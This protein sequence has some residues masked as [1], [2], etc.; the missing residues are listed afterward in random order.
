MPSLKIR[1][2]ENKIL[3]ELTDPDSYELIELDAHWVAVHQHRRTKRGRPSVSEAKTIW[4]VTEIQTGSFIA[5]G[6]TRDEV[7]KLAKARVDKLK[8][9]Q[10]LS[11]PIANAIKM[12]RKLT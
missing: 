9:E 8:Q 11:D 12:L 6:P 5:K 10:K 1:N 7:I 4:R 2:Y 3:Y